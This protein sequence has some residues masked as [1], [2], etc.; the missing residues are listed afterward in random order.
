MLTSGP[1][2][3]TTYRSEGAQ[4]GKR[5]QT[6]EDTSKP[7]VLSVSSGYVRGEEKALTPSSMSCPGTW[8]FIPHKPVTKFIGLSDQLDSP[9]CLTG[10]ET[11]IKTVPK[12]V[13]LDNTS[14]I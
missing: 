2:I 4:D 11:H 1:D 14:L 13:N 3:G 12:A 7:G 8:T 10:E 5:H 9:I 6:P